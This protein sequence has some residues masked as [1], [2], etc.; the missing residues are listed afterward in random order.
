LL[1]GS[2]PSRAAFCASTVAIFVGRTINGAG[3]PALSR[4]EITTPP[5]NP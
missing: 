5:G 3:S 4:L 2:A 1:V